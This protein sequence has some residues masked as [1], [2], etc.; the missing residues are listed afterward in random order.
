[1]LGDSQILFLC[2]DSGSHDHGQWSRF[3]KANLHHKKKD[4]H[5]A[6]GS[7]E[8]DQ[9]S[10]LVGGGL[11]NSFLV[12]AYDLWGIFH[13]ADG[14]DDRD[15]IPGERYCVISFGGGKQRNAGKKQDLGQAGG[16]RGWGGGTGSQPCSMA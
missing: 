14:R 8:Q 13:I 6:W 5:A 1:M 10:F 4:R 16:K 11:Q 7:S 15:C 12:V 9:A 3:A 2:W